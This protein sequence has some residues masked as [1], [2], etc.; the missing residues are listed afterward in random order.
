[1]SRTITRKDLEL[2]GTAGPIHTPLEVPMFAADAVADWIPG[3][4]RRVSPLATGPP[5]QMQITALTSTDGE[6]DVDA[7]LLIRNF[8]ELAVALLATESQRAVDSHKSRSTSSARQVWRHLAS[9]V[10]PIDLVRMHRAY[11]APPSSFEWSSFWAKLYEKVV[12]SG[13]AEAG[14]G[15]H[16]QQ[17]V[18][19]FMDTREAQAEIRD[20][21]PTDSARPDRRAKLP[22]YRFVVTLGSFLEAM[23]PHPLE[24]YDKAILARRYLNDD[25]HQRPT[26]AATPPPPPPPRKRG[27]E[28]MHRFDMV[29]TAYV[30]TTVVH[31]LRGQQQPPLSIGLARVQERE[32]YRFVLEEVTGSTGK[33]RLYWHLSHDRQHEG[34][35]DD[36]DDG[37]TDDEG[38]ADGPEM[39]FYMRKN[40]RIG[41]TVR[42]NPDVFSTV[43]ELAGKAPAWAAGMSPYAND[44]AGL[45][46]DHPAFLPRFKRFLFAMVVYG[47][48]P[49]VYFDWNSMPADVAE[50]TKHAVPLPRYWPIFNF[51]RATLYFDHQRAPVR[52][53]SEYL[54]VE[55]EDAPP[56]RL[57]RLRFVRIK[58]AD[59]SKLTVTFDDYVQKAYRRETP[60]FKPADYW[61]AA[62]AKS[63]NDEQVRTTA[64]NDFLT[65]LASRPVA[66]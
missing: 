19:K 1:L 17:I 52:G 21:G 47:F 59:A 3:E 6:G 48:C 61:A 22:H 4:P 38:P 13:K 41:R 50:A 33:R 7:T 15:L 65:V 40:L 24:V 32:F 54:F 35:D 23:C 29:I 28:S 37:E 43:P 26:A 36:G 2:T 11:N 66:Y 10:F 51:A 14:P 55:D 30:S 18:S 20:I 46:L 45:T 63:L 62:F 12:L 31:P 58:T 49:V 44:L 53:N 5:M 8:G 64:I 34:S 9:D 27:R 16:I 57:E 56:E 42:F 25:L 39:I 60:A